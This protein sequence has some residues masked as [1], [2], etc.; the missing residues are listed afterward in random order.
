MAEI[1]EPT[2]TPVSQP[3]EEP[4]QTP[5]SQPVEESTPTAEPPTPTPQ[6]AQVEVTAATV[7][8]RSG[9][10]TNYN[11][12]GQASRG[13]TFEVLARDENGEWLQ[14]QR[15]NGNNAWVINDTALDKTHRRYH[16]RGSSAKY[17]CPATNRQTRSHQTA[18]PHQHTCAYLPVC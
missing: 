9:P 6:V 2:P 7:N 8:L 11:R 18:G 16:E 1:E 14:I 12:V 4:T 17:P 10:G 13:Q 15:P 5:V 3:Q